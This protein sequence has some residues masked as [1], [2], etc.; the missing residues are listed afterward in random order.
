L[1]TRTHVE[2]GLV[3]TALIRG[4]LTL[5]PDIYRLIELAEPAWFAERKREVGASRA[6][7]ILLVEDSLFFRQLVA[8]YFESEGYEVVVAADGKEGYDRF[9]KEAIDIIVSDIQMPIM[10]GVEFI[11]KVRNESAKR[12]V[13][14]IALT[15]LRSDKDRERAMRAGYNYYEIKL[16]REQLLH[17]VQECGR[18]IAH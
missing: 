16:E 3:G 4:R 8:G 7:R 11:R 13:P 9:E 17:T 6:L 14:A 1:N 18:H 12:R 15:S 2:D 10:D 5:L